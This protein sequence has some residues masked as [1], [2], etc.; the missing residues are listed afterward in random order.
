[1]SDVLLVRHGV[2]EWNAAHRVQG[3][4]DM[5]LTAEARAWLERHAP[6]SRFADARWRASPLRRAVDTAQLLGARGLQIEERLIEM[7]WG[8]WEGLTLAEMRAEDAAAMR[9]NEARGLDFRARGGESPR[10]VAARLQ[11][12]F[13]RVAGDGAD[14]VAVT[15]KG[16]IRAALALATGWDMRE[17]F[18]RRIDWRAGQHF[19]VARRGAGCVI[20]LAA[21]NVALEP[22]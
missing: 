10:D 2:T 19:H 17:D 3:R 12:W 4:I 16:V 15:H 9:R 22:R 20:T 13:T 6:P 18:P 11:Q 5:P 8:A 1:M 7:D 14:V 21:L